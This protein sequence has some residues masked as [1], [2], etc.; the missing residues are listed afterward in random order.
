MVV[1]CDHRAA[2]TAER[3]EEMYS[4]AIYSDDH[5]KTWKIGGVVGV[6]GTNESAVVELSDGSVYLNCRDQ[7]KR[8][9]RCAAWS[10]DDGETFGEVRWEEALIEPACQASLERVGDADGGQAILFCNPASKTRDTLT[11]RASRDDARTW[12][13]GRVLEAGRA[14]Y[15]D[16]AVL[17]DGTIL[18][19]YERGAESPYEQLTLARFDLEWVSDG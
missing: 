16:L 1:A 7:H 10:G 2:P 17:H 4:H 5:G 19:L 3:G 13:A 15:S 14:A 8:G 6:E 9:R 12:G 18:C 11:V